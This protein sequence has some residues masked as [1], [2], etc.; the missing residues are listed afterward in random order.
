MTQWSQK[1]IFHQFMQLGLA[2]IML[3]WHQL[4]KFYAKRP[5]VYPISQCSP[6]MMHVMRKQTFK[7]FVIVIPKEGWA[8]VAMPIL[9]LAWYWLFKNIIYDVSGVKFWKF[10]VIPKEGWVCVASTLLK[11]GSW[12][13]NHPGQTGTMTVHPSYSNWDHDNYIHPALTGTMT[14]TSILH[15]LGPWKYSHPALTGTMPM[16]P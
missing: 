7:V 3:H 16:H 13:C 9:L 15:L 6:H 1:V 5:H 12:Q 4:L 2:Q 14:I 10:C 8:R 11:L